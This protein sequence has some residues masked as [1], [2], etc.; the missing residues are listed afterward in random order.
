MLWCFFCL[1]GKGCIDDGFGETG[2]H[3]TLLNV[4]K[5]YVGVN[6]DKAWCEE[7]FISGRGM[8]SVMVCFCVSFLSFTRS[9]KGNDVYSVLLQDI[10][11]Q[12]TTFCEQQ[13]IDP[14]VSC[15]TDYE[16]LL[17]CI[18][19]GL[20]L[21]TAVIQ[22][23]NS[24]RTL[25]GNQVGVGCFPFPAA[26][27]KFNFSD[28]FFFFWLVKDGIYSSDEYVVYEETADGGVFGVGDD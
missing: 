23:D 21:N 8:K 12:L 9:R 28:F 1:W 2:D 3:I 14:E 4:L 27:I 5:G 7:N 18:L 13:D 6:G 26:S 17:K 10:K 24:Y 19:S 16:P 22:P 11:S 15:G 25:V 20:F